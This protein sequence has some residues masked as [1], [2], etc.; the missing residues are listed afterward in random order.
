MKSENSLWKESFRKSQLLGKTYSI[1][2]AGFKNIITPFIQEKINQFGKDSPIGLQFLPRREE[3]DPEWTQGGLKDPI[4]DQEFL[5]APGLIHRYENRA[6]FVPT[7]V[8][9]VHCRY[10][11]RR[12]DI[13][14]D[15]II[16]QQ[17]FKQAIHYLE[18]H[19]EI[20][21]VIFTGGDPLSLDDKR[22]FEYASK[23]GKIK[24]IKFLRFHTR[25]LTTIPER[26]TDEFLDMI[27]ELERNFEQIIFVIH[28]N[29]H[30]EICEVVKRAIKKLINRNIIILSQSVLLKDVNDSSECLIKLFKKLS[31]LGVR[32]YYLHH[33]DKVFGAQ[34]FYLSIEE[35]RRI[36]HQVRSKLSG[37]M[38][39]KYVLD[40]PSGGGKVPAYNSE[41]F[42]F[43]G[44]LINRKGILE[45]YHPPFTKLC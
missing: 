40:L 2:D 21:E 26:I 14:E 30:L 19:P 12:N 39:P 15:K 5:V 20:N 8:C 32:P 44:Q 38:I 13:G 41:S 7:S 35:G 4:S 42:E 10:C 28:I 29:S 23:I 43:H 25:F 22:I 11:F 34:H 24:S 18:S 27:Q 9:P 45:N 3:T 6:L 1:P 36:Y 17:D 16:F 37:W 33:P 31:S